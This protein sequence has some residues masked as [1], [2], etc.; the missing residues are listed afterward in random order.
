MGWD[1]SRTLSPI[2]HW[3]QTTPNV[4][5]GLE[6]GQPAHLLLLTLG[7]GDLNADDIPDLQEGRFT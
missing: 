5:S 7:G 4:V 3:S 2:M 1:G 6:T